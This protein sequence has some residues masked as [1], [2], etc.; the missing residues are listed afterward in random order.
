MLSVDSFT[1][2]ID[3]TNPD[4]DKQLR[5][6]RKYKLIV[7]TFRSMS[8]PSILAKSSTEYQR[9]A[10]QSTSRRSYVIYVPFLVI[11]KNMSALPYM[12]RNDGVVEHIYEYICTYL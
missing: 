7:K 1:F 5:H 4:I 8:R 11:L 10:N 3:K 12:K 6:N 9:M 2:F